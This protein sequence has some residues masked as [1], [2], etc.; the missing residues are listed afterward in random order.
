M[1][2]D[3]LR[4]GRKHLNEGLADAALSDFRSAL[5]PWAGRPIAEDAYEDWAKD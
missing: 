4:S 5:G 1:F 3:K 2:L